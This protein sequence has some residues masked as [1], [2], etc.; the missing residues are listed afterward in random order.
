MNEINLNSINDEDEEDFLDKDYFT[1][2]YPGQNI[3]D[4][5]AFKK[6]YSFQSE[7]IKTENEIRINNNKRETSEYLVKEE[8]M[9][10]SSINYLFITMCKNCQCYT[11]HSITSQSVFA[12]CLKCE[13]EFCVGCA[14]E[15][16][17]SDN[18]KLCFMGY[19]KS[20]YLRMSIGDYNGKDLDIMEYIFLFFITIIIMPIYLALISCVSYLNRHPNKLFVVNEDEDEND[21]KINKYMEIYK[22]IYPIF[23]S[24]LYF[25]YIIYF[26]P[27]LLITTSIIFSIQKLRNKFLI[28]Y[29]PLIGSI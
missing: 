9:S 7:K 18:T 19:F 21:I 3:S 24:L 2:D 26:F 29:E 16:Y 27:F 17:S 15:K 14:M 11:R 8:E 23:F 13:K 22:V 25:V 6:W 12:K 10:K 4:N 5:T 28:I 20:L 1:I